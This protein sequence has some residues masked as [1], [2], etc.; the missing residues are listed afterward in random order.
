MSSKA[1][2]SSAV[3]IPASPSCSLSSGDLISACDN[4][5][6]TFLDNCS[7]FSES[8]ALIFWSIFIWSCSC[9]KAVFKALPSRGMAPPNSFPCRYL[10]ISEFRSSEMIAWGSLSRRTRC[11]NFMSSVITFPETK[12]P[13]STSSPPLNFV[14]YIRSTSVKLKL[15][16]LRSVNA[17]NWLVASGLLSHTSS[18]S[19]SNSLV[20][21]TPT[22]WVILCNRFINSLCSPPI[23]SICSS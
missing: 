4:S 12:G 13:K 20:N 1:S 19:L 23:F 3:V 22:R 17:V 5:L 21:P 8:T 9:D 2:R 18:G 11:A 15:L 14:S 16:S 6:P 7:N 10:D